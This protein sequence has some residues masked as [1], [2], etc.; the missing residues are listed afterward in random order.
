MMVLMDTR[1]YI[2]IEEVAD[3]LSIS[4]RSV[5]Y[6]ISHINQL[7]EENGIS[8]I[9]SKR[10]FG[11]KLFKDTREYLTS[12]V[13]PAGGMQ[14]VYFSFSERAAIIV[15]SLY[16]NE[17]NA[18]ELADLCNISER[19]I[20]DDIDYLRDELRPFKLQIVF[21]KNNG[22]AIEGSILSIRTAVIYYLHAIIKLQKRGLL[23]E[24]WFESSEE[25]KQKLEVIELKSSLSYANQLLKR[26]SYVIHHAKNQQISFTDYSDELLD[27][28]IYKLVNEEFHNL[29]K[30][31]QYYITMVLVSARQ[32]GINPE[33]LSVVKTDESLMTTI[34]QIIEQYEWL[35]QVKFRDKNNLANSLAH[36]IYFS[37]KQFSY[38]ILDNNIL[39]EEVQ[40]EY[41]TVYNLTKKMSEKVWFTLDYPLTE[42]EIAYLTLIFGSYLKNQNYFKTRVLIVCANGVSTSLMLKQEISLLSSDIDII[43]TVSVNEL[44]KYLNHIDLVISTIPL[45]VDIPSVIVNPIMTQSDKVNVLRKIEQIND[46]V[47]GRNTLNDLYRKIAPFIEVENQADVKKIFDEFS[48]ISNM[49]GYHSSEV[50]IRD[51]VDNL[52]IEVINKNVDWKQSILLSGK[53]LVDGNCIKENYLNACIQSIEDNGA[54]SLFPNMMYLAHAKPDDGVNKL[55]VS[56][57]YYPNIV[58]F[59]H[60]SKV[61]FV[62][63]LGTVDNHVHIKVLNQVIS[64]FSNSKFTEEIE[65]TKPNQVEFIKMIER[66]LD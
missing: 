3:F 59:P 16:C 58:N 41:Q 1:S 12:N 36:H 52:N 45:E 21:K 11:V 39:K 37:R 60:E 20:Y 48:E 49:K 55:C 40:L 24:D 23:E 15:C 34:N 46:S 26:L 33:I 42:D 50:D 32:I 25:I 64:L 43:D 38:G 10:Y 27:N 65:C 35:A 54:Y 2:T 6:S 63:V 5:Y 57:G 19:T 53:S 30:D 47:V 4:T 31:E 62:V 28:A 9:A 22:Y 13:S 29:S 14:N 51:I 18:S 7:L 17:L 56:V 66:Y 44:E 8:K 61:K